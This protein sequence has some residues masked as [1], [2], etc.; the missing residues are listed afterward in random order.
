MFEG[1]SDRLDQV[2]RKLRGWGKLTKSNIEEALRDIR[3]AFLEADVHYQVVTD[4][5]DQVK[6]RALGKEV[7]ESLTPGQ[8]FI[9]IVRDEMTVI[10][11]KKN[12]A[13]DL[14]GSAPAGIMLV[15][16]QG[17]GKTTTAAKLA[18]HLR[19]E[20]GRKPLLMALDT[21][22]PAAAEQLDVLAQR[23]NVACYRGE[24][25][26]DIPSL[27]RGGYERAREHGHDVLIADT[28][29][30][31][32]IDRELMDELILVQREL[33]PR[34]TLLVLDAMAG[35]DAVRVAQAFAEE[36]QISGLV[37][38][39]L[40][41][42]ARGGAA[43]SVRSATGIPIKFQ[44]IGEK[45]S[46][47][48]PFHPDRLANRILGM[49][50]MLSLIEKAESVWEEGQGKALEMKFGSG[51]FDLEDFVGQFQAL[52]KMGSMESI[53]GMIPGLKKAA[54]GPEQLKTAEREMVRFE[55]IIRSMTPQE[56]RT[57]A[58][59][60]GSRRKRIAA[61][62]GTT[63]AD[64]NRLLKRFQAVKKLMKGKPGKRRRGGI[65]DFLPGTFRV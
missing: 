27:I 56:R 20:S 22:R 11:G 62:S 45:E 7:A 8:Q 46:D 50:D 30:R 28:A 57:P 3:V 44:G 43:L 17:S 64:V 53:M 38:T 51:K 55:A 21:R 42:D 40:D 29:G 59:V 2:S 52:K 15:G 26:S 63:P 58:I 41:G 19:Q 36:V 4:F 13:L 6:I 33:K 60:K 31:L 9:K 12:E 18:Y 34:E 47:L 48:E 32:H 1:I 39:K 61:G 24:H 25:E 23:V 49:G 37:L 10:L 65:P 5:L 35:Q 16:L 14:S 54:V